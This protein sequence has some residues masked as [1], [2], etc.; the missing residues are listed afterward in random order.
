MLAQR[1]KKRRFIFRV[2]QK[3]NHIPPF[4]ASEASAWLSNYDIYYFSL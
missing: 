4:C 1:Q 2:C 3:M